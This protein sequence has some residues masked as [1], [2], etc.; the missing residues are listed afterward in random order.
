MLF[1]IIYILIGV[2]NGLLNT[3]FPSIVEL[4]IEDCPLLSKIC[5]FF[6]IIFLWPIVWIGITIEIIK[7]YKK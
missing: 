5:E 6:F 1:V 7:Y 3:I 4:E 2:F